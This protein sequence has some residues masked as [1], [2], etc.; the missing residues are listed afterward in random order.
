[1]AAA[2]SLNFPAMA[3]ARSSPHDAARSPPARCRPA[4][5]RRPTAVR[6]VPPYP[7]WKSWRCRCRAAARFCRI[8]LAPPSAAGARL[9]RAASACCR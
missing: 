1:M 7:R 6:T 8:V 2:A 4:T 5:V 9:A 3:K